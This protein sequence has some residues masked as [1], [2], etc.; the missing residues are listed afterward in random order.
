[1][2]WNLKN[3]VLGA[4]KNER[5]E[6]LIGLR[7]KPWGKN[8]G[9]TGETGRCWPEEAHLGRGRWQEA[10]TQ[11]ELW[12]PRDLPGLTIF[13]S[14]HYQQ[15]FFF[16][17]ENNRLKVTRI[18]ITRVPSI[19]KTLLFNPNLSDHVYINYPNTR[20]RKQLKFLE[21]ESRFEQIPT[22]N[23]PMKDA[24]YP[25]SLGTCRSKPQADPTTHPWERL[26]QTGL[27]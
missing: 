11:E 26:E 14:L 18:Q 19:Q 5:Y 7:T 9:G 20:T 16:L 8:S 23:K 27:W 13:L 17:S 4:G 1:M 12:L 21:M 22:L 15:I 25:L 3:E 24:Q 2:W 6:T 10:P